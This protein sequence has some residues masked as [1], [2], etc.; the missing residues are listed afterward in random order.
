[1]EGSGLQSE[2]EDL[3]QLRS[4][5]A[6]DLYP[7]KAKPE[8]PP[9]EKASS[10]KKHKDK[11]KSDRSRSREHK[12]EKEHKK[13]RKSR[14]RSRDRRRACKRLEERRPSPEPRKAREERDNVN[15]VEDLEEEVEEESPV[16][17]SPEREPGEQTTCLWTQ[18]FSVASAETS[19]ISG[20]LESHPSAQACSLHSW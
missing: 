8:K 11:K 4:H 5:K 15:P 3:E 14:S 6:I 17:G 13:K 10:S 20:A 12:T 9:K 2:G 19:L 16:R 18:S 1:M 7:E